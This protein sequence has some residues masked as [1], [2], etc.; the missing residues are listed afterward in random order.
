MV[1]GVVQVGQGSA[2]EEWEVWEEAVDLAVVV[3]VV[4]D[5][6]REEGMGW[7][8]DWAEVVS[9]VVDRAVG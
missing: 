3:L 5:S 4:W 9:A 2:G 8:V 1:A 6:A 7:A